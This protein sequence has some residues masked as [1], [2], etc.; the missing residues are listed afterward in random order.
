M[1]RVLVVVAHAMMLGVFGCGGARHAIPLTLEPRITLLD[2]GV[3]PRQRLHFGWK[4]NAPEY[5]EIDLKR[6]NAVTTVNTMLE[7]GNRRIEMP[8]MRSV[9]RIEVLELS[10]S[11]DAVVVFDLASVSLLQDVVIDPPRE[12]VSS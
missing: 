10:A 9:W 4:R 5:I 1:S 11:G 12:R 6:T 8:T 7:T 2:A 3:A